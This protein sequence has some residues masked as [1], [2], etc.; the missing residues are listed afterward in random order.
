M[1][2]DWLCKNAS[3]KRLTS[4]ARRLLLTVA[5]GLELAALLSS[6]GFTEDSQMHRAKGKERC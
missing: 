5:T 4:K 1:K 3:V 6:V 2:R